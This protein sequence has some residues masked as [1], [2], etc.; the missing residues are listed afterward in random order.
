VTLADVTE[1]L[2]GTPRPGG[3]ASDIGA[4]EIAGATS[5][6]TLSVT[7]SGSGSGTVTSAPAGIDCGVDC[8]QAYASGTTVTLTATAGTGSSFTGWGGACAGTDPCVVTM[9]N[10]ASVT[11]TFALLPPPGQP[12]LVEVSVSN[13]PA[14]V[15][16]KASFSVTDTVRNEGTGAAGASTTSYFLSVDAVRNGG[17][18]LLTG[19]RAVPAL[20]AGAQ[21]TGTVSVKVPNSMAL[22]TYFL[23]ACADETHVVAETSDANNCVAST[24][25]KVTVTK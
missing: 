8:S 16:R 12:D 13:P 17:D 23:L 3:P 4:F 5:N 24:T 15:R 21:S 14:T 19:G 18:R 9:S 25:T 1:D 7:V 2:E 22:G 11:A 20:A 6:A 10:D